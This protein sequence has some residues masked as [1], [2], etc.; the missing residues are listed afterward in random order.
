VTRDTR[1]V[2][3]DQPLDLVWMER[4]HTVVFGWAD[5]TN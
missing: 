3:C 4:R 2:S 5:M 1:E